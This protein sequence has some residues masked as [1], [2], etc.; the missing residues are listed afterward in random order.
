MEG[1]EMKCGALPEA[2]LPFGRIGH[3]VKRSLNCLA[4]LNTD[5]IAILRRLI[6]RGELR[7]KLSPRLCS[8]MAP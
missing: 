6:P 3:V 8:P 1:M 7:R 4:T 5:R 2:P